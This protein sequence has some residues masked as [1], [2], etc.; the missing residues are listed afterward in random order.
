MGR[1]AQGFFS[2]DGYMRSIPCDVEDYV[3][4]QINNGQASKVQAWQNTIYTEIV[5]FYPRVTEIDSYVSYNY[6]E[7]HWSVGT[8]ARTAT[9][10][11]GIFNFPIMF[12]SS[13]NPYEHEV[14]GTYQDTGDD[15]I[16]PY[17]ESGPIELGNGNRT[18]SATGLIP[19]VTALGDITTSFYTRMYPTDSDTEH[20]PFT[21]TQPTSVRFTG[22]TV[23]MRCTSDSANA[24]KVGVPRLKMQAGG[25]R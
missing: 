9:T 16:V 6:V 25:K 11:R 13:G 18:M 5:W 17:V 2:Y 3:I 8:L 7:D 23:R 19:D 20:G 22:R 24:W 12:D 14:G 1:S 4:S 15:A 10:S 21:M